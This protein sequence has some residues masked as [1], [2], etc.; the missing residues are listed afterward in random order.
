MS[1]RSCPLL[2]REAFGTAELDND[3]EDNTYLTLR[4]KK[5][6]ETTLKITDGDKVYLYDVVSRMENGHN[7]VHVTLQK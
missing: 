7:Q 5:Y 3:D 4:I 1:C 6:G 2:R